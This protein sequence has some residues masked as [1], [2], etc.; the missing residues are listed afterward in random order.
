MTAFWLLENRKQ[1]PLNSIFLI[2]Y[3]LAGRNG[4]KKSCIVGA[5]GMLR[6]T[7]WAV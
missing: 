5:P 4:V 2:F 6:L 3:P 7:M 1:T